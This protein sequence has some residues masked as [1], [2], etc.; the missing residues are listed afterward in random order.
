MDK[1]II[2][3]RVDE[4]LKE[5]AETLFASMGTSMSEAIRIFLKQCILNQ[6]F[7]FQ[8][9]SYA[10]K[11]ENSAYGFLKRPGARSLDLLA[12]EKMITVLDESAILRYLLD[13]ERKKARQVA[14]VI[15]SGQAYSFPEVFARVAVTLRDVYLVPRSLISEALLTLLNDISVGE[16]DIVRYATRL[17]GTTLF[18]YIDCLLV[19]RNHLYEFDVVT[20]DKPLLKHMM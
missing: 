3:V 1:S 7:P 16:E 8:V 14:E 12:D 20:F 9:K 11:G 19:A 13:D 5:Q 10:Q 2:H 6:K 15:A 4:D 17:F 18:D